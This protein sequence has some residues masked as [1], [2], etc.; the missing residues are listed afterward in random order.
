M[1]FYFVKKKKIMSNLK[2][3]KN[4]V[5][6]FMK[7]CAYIKQAKVFVLNLNLTLSIHAINHII[8]S[9]NLLRTKL[10]NKFALDGT[11]LDCYYP[12]KIKYFRYHDTRCFL[13][14]SN[15]NVKL[16]V[17]AIMQTSLSRIPNFMQISF[18]L[19]KN[20][21]CTIIPS[22]NI[23]TQLSK[24]IRFCDKYLRIEVT[25]WANHYYRSTECLFDI[26]S[27]N[28]MPLNSL[29][30]LPLTL[31]IYLTTVNQ[32]HVFQSWHILPKLVTI[33]IG[34]TTRIMVPCE[35][36]KFQN[37]LVFICS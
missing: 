30:R 27:I 32:H 16:K 1:Y 25:E 13:I 5:W 26:E 36:T 19:G 29:F 7:S 17:N 20:L 21:Q 6:K 33:M 18:I 23:G 35:V 12:I 4:T 37:K 11:T 10:S 8:I 9:E 31:P 15:N 24:Q 22:V 14:F 2:F 28:D 34:K 3:F